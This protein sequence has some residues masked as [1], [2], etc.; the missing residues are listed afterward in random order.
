MLRINAWIYASH[1]RSMS[2]TI[3]R[4]L[5][6]DWQNRSSFSFSGW[7]APKHG[8]PDQLLALDPPDL[9]I[10]IHLMVHPMDIGVYHHAKC[11][12]VY[13][14]WCGGPIRNSSVTCTINAKK[15]FSCTY[16]RFSWYCW[17][18]VPLLDIQQQTLAPNRELLLETSGPFLVTNHLVQVHV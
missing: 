13:C 6:I 3:T 11:L 17:Y 1:Y 9:R 5:S 14:W 12:C 8:H 16:V 7:T 15:V 18:A 2:L 4:P 10:S